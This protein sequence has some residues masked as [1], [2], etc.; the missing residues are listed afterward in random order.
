MLAHVVLIC[1]TRTISRD[2]P[3]EDGQ[4]RII[5]PATP[6]YPAALESYVLLVD[7][8]YGGEPN[9]SDWSITNIAATT[10]AELFKA[11][12]LLA[13]LKTRSLGGAYHRLHSTLTL[14]LVDVSNHSAQ[15][16]SRLFLTMVD[17]K[18]YSWQALLLRIRLSSSIPGTSSATA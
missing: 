12:R 4:T 15:P 6:F 8:T 1:K 17:R 2:I 16:Y 18:R 10:D 5:R 7:G 13:D 9:T 11:V 3:I 14:S